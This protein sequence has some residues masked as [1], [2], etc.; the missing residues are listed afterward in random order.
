[1]IVYD[2]FGLTIESAVRLG[3][4]PPT[5]KTDHVPDVRIREV[6]LGSKIPPLGAAAPSFQ[7]EDD[8]G[9]MMIWPG[10]MSVRVVNQALIEFQRYH[11]APERFLGFPLLGPVM[12]WLLHL[13]GLFVLHAS[14]VEW[15][16]KTVSFLGDKGAGKSTTA[17]SFLKAGAKLITDDLLAIDATNNKR[18]VIFPAYPQIK[19]TE[20]ATEVVQLTEAECLPSMPEIG[21]NQFRLNSMQ[22]TPMLCDYVLIL[23]RDHSGPK[24]DWLTGHDALTGLIRY[25]YNSRFNTAPIRLQKLDLHLKSC[26]AITNSSRIGRFSVPPHAA[27]LGKAVSYLEDLISS[28]NS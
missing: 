15:K 11:D 7:F 14:S 21:K 16:G 12:G 26:A 22:T 3:E 6:D 9:C 20:E 2:A 23:N 17:A 1:M 25:S 19:L 5:S 18:P 4:L 8:G 27:R 28:D 24:I 13:R 10:V